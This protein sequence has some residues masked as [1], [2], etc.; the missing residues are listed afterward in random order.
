M[1]RDCKCSGVCCGPQDDGVNRRDFLSL[2]GAGAATAALSGMAWAD[3]V[4]QRMPAEELARWKKSLLQPSSPRV[5]R[6][7]VH[8][9]A[10]LHL[11]GIGTGNIELGCDGQFVNW[12]LF[13]TLKDGY[14]PLMFLVK[15]GGEA[16]LLQ[17]AGGPNW[18]RVKQ[19]E[20]TGEY[21]IATL[22]YLDAD[23]PVRVQLSAFTPFAPLDTR[24]S[25][26]PLV[27]LVFRI[28]NPGTEA[29]E[30]SL[31][32]LMQNPVGYDTFKPLSGMGYPT[33]GGNVNEPMREGAATGL[34]MRAEPGREG[35]GFGRRH[36]AS[37]RW[38]WCRWLAV[39][40]LGRRSTIGMPLGTNSSSAAHGC[41]PT[42][43]SPVRRRPPAKPL[44]AA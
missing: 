14:V 28:E 1:G 7:G 23:L 9:D 31:C 25:S 8:T 20:M 21:P 4:Q 30:V 22:R 24:F 5:Y 11:G 35:A 16:R 29:Q 33:L 42:K 10:H 44:A 43:R 27:V 17:T 38:P 18:P 39:S 15:A 37:A 26:Q 2:A 3:W 12:Q 40:R 34:L 41:R 19:I 36:A 6:S 32:A 13:N